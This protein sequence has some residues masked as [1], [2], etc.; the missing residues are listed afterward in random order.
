MIY[1][2]AGLGLVLYVFIKL[3]HRE[4]INRGIK[5]GFRESEKRDRVRKDLYRIEGYDQALKVFVT[6]YEH[7][8]EEMIETKNWAEFKERDAEEKRKVEEYHRVLQQGMNERKHILEAGL[9]SGSR[10]AF[11]RLQGTLLGGFDTEEPQADLRE[12]MD[13]LRGQLPDRKIKKEDE[14]EPS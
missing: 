8:K 7:W 4:V 6:A 5:I 10:R 9:G 3:I 14:N 1:L 13:R 11:G 2:Y 12:L